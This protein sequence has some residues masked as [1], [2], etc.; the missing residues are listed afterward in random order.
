MYKGWQRRSVF[1]VC[2]IYL[3]MCLLNSDTNIEV[4][5]EQIKAYHAELAAVIIKLI[6]YAL[7]I[8]RYFAHV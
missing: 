3:L 7:I 5:I 8:H 1:Q 4:F 6:G 2:T